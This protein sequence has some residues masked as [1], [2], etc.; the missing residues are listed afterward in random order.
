MSDFDVKERH[1]EENIE[2]YLINQGGYTKGNPASFN[3]YSGLDEAIF[4]EFIKNISL[5][6]GRDLKPFMVI[7]L[8]NKIRK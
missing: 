5:N 3:R 1:F 4:V 7:L 2:S 6:D 8:N